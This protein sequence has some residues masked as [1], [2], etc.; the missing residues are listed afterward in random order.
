M[1]LNHAVRHGGFVQGRRVKDNSK[2]FPM[3]SF[4]VIWRLHWTVCSRLVAGAMN[5][6]PICLTGAMLELPACKCLQA[7]QGALPHFQETAVGVGLASSQNTVRQGAH[8]AA[9]VTTVTP[10]LAENVGSNPHLAAI[11]PVFISRY[12]SINIKWYNFMIL[13]FCDILDTWTQSVGH[14]NVQ[15]PQFKSKRVNFRNVWGT[16]V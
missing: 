15:V 11:F 14:F 2:P 6:L 13:S 8:A 12:Y 16:N 10:R 5:G 1:Q 3:C 4:Y 9:I 7:P